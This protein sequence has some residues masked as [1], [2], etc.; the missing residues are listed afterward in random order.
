M[1]FSR[2]H[3]IELRFAYEWFVYI[4]KKKYAVFKKLCAERSTSRMSKHLFQS[5]VP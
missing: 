4:L 1:S 2:S 3:N 5:H